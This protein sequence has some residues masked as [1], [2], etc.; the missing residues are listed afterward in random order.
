MLIAHVSPRTM[1]K[2]TNASFLA[3]AMHERGYPMIGFDADHSKQFTKWDEKAKFPFPVLGAA[4]ET[5]HLN[6]PKTL[7]PNHFAMIDCGHAEDHIGVTTSVLR[8]VDLAILNSSP[9]TSDLYRI[10]DLPMRKIIDDVAP[11]RMDSEPPETWV[12]LNRCPTQSNSRAVPEARKWFAKRGWNVFTTT[13]PSLQQYSQA[14]PFPVKAAGSH[15]DQLVTE[16]KDR[17]LIP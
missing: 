16:M 4:S 2:T 15:L 10:R 13:V 8:C 11:L 9:S 6:V 12:L 5:F 17:G 7:P 14:Y 1:G 3:H